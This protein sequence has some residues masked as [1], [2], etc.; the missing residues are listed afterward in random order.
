MKCPLCEERKGK[1]ACKVNAGQLICPTCCASVRTAACEGCSHYQASLAYQRDKQVTQRHFTVELL[2]DVDDRCDVA[3][4]LAEKGQLAQAE[5]LLEDLRRQYPNYH[6]VLYGVGVCHG[7]RGNLDQAIACLERAV[8]T[9]P[10]FEHAHYNLG[11]AYCKKVHIEKAVR[12][13]EKVIALDG[14]DGTVGSRARQQL[15]GLE[16]IVGSHGVTLAT[17][18]ENMRTFDRAFEALRAGKYRLSIDLFARVLH[19]DPKH[20]QSYGNMGLAHACL[21]NREKALEC[22]D[23]AIELDPQYEPAIVNRLAVSSLAE[24]E[25]LPPLGYREISYYSEF[26]DG[27]KSYVQHLLSEMAADGHTPAARETGAS[28]IRGA[29]SRSSRCVGVGEAGQ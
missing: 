18:V 3:L 29:E 14:R 5:A 17:Y 12:A 6:T 11:L 1:R 25:A 8:E 20:V 24:G 23:K 26:R 21:G 10:M 13:F 9:F 4:G 28:M 22:L 15:D 27:D 2:P 16:A 19:A 7:L